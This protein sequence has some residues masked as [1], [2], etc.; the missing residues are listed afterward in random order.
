M[1]YRIVFG[2]GLLVA[3]VVAFVANENEANR[4]IRRISTEEAAVRVG[5]AA[6]MCFAADGIS[7]DTLCVLVG[8]K[9]ADCTGSNYTGCRANNGTTCTEKYEF[10]LFCGVQYVGPPALGMCLAA[11]CSTQTPNPCGV[12]PTYITG[13]ACP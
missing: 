6:N 1:H 3:A 13:T 4:H 8:S 2:I 10:P 9:C 12:K 11:Q 7:C 5:G